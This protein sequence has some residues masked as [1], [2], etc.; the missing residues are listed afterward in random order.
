M[1]LTIVGRP[2]EALL[3]EIFPRIV[4]EPVS[5]VKPTGPGWPGL[6]ISSVL[7]TCVLFIAES[8]S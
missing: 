2:D 7:S 6:L 5:G 1:V 4:A 3:V 8:G